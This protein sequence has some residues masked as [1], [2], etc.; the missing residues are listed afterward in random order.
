MQVANLRKYT[1]TE[2]NSAGLEVIDCDNG[3]LRFLI[4]ASCALDIMQL[5]HEGQNVSFISKNGFTAKHTDFPSRFEGG[6]LYTCG[7]DSIGAR[8]GFET[9]GTLHEKR[10]TVTRTECTEDGITVE[11]YITDTALFG[12]NLV[13]KRKI[14]SALG[15]ESVTVEDTLTNAGARVE[16]FCV[17]YHVNV[18]YPMID[19]GARIEADVKACEPRNEWAAQ[20][21]ENAFVTEA[22]LPCREETCYY[23]TLGKPEVS[24][25]NSAIGK[26]FTLAYEGEALTNFIE[27][28]SMACGD[29]ALGLEPCTSGLDDKFSYKSL[30]IGQST[31]N[32]ITLTV[33]KL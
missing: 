18:G 6:M 32:V 30:A 22:P 24:V 1:L 25:I 7:L 15:S 21:A 31:K 2:G 17:L 4:N 10:A 20:N 26:K 19:D 9:H 13:L 27:W 23:L 28:K 33:T 11:G 5:F 16:N 8:D 12:K 29:Y 3:R 14:Y